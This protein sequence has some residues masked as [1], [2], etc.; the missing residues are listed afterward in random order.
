MQ[1]ISIPIYLKLV[2]FTLVLLGGSLVS[3]VYYAVETFKNDKISY[4]YESVDDYNDKLANQLK[5]KKENTLKLLS[6]IRDL[7]F[8]NEF[9][10][11]TMQDNPELTSYVEFKDGKVKRILSSQIHHE[12]KFETKKAQYEALAS[13]TLKASGDML[14][15]DGLLLLWIH[16]GEI[17][18]KDSGFKMGFVTSLNDFFPAPESSLYQNDFLWSNQY[19]NNFLK[20]LV[21]FLKANDSIS[22]TFILPS[23]NERIVSLRKIS[24]KLSLVTSTDFS[25]A[26]QASSS[27]Q[28][29]SIYFGFLVAGISMILVLVFS[30]LVTG[31]INKLT[32]VVDG[33]FETGF[34]QRSEVVSSDEIGFL[35]RSFNKM[36]DQIVGYIEQMK[37]KAKMEQELQTANLVQSQFFP[38]ELFKNSACQV[39]GIFKSASECGGD[40]WSVYQNEDSTVVILADVTGHGTPAALMTA[41]LHSSLNSL[42]Y[43]AQLDPRYNSQPD[44][45]MQFLND[46]FLSSTNKLNATA[47]VMCFNEKTNEV[48]YTN[49]SHNPPFFLRVSEGE[50]D[51]SKII[52]LLE[53]N[54]ARLGEKV[55]GSYQANIIKV[56]DKDKVVLYTDGILEGINSEDKAY[57]Q[58]RFIKEV[59]AHQTCAAQDLSKGVMED[60]YSFIGETDLQDDITFITFEVR[61]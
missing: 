58:R 27:L 28:K 10:L 22:Q 16:V 61:T 57:G 1:K 36:A 59:L 14:M 9:I 46:S 23:Q 2:F 40:W 54:G 13:A 4:V 24:N 47:F 37:V 30:S 45:I 17:K 15:E 44:L 49:A 6:Y 26:L 38:Q 18:N 31:P 7:N 21:Q 19:N 25:N 52:P 32:V 53:N 5:L 20:E 8:Q 35:S 29:N 11:R 60:F 43:L 34:Q 39:S 51:K 56:S 12:N 48:N 3:Y 50:I 42:K 33:F 55:D 41:V